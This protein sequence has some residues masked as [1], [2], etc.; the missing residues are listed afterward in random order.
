MVH[1]EGI[2]TDIIYYNEE[3]GYV[4][5]ILETEDE[6]VSIKG[7]I[8]FAQEGDRIRVSGQIEM[9]STYGEQLNVKRSEHLKPTEAE[10]ILKYLSSG[11]ITGIGEATAKLLV[12]TFGEQTLTIIEKEPHRLLEIPGIGKKKLEGIILSYQEQFALRDY[13][14]FFQALGLT[15]NMAMKIHKRYGIEGIDVVERNPYVLADDVIG[16]GFKLADQ[17]ALKMGMALDSPF[18]IES[19]ILYQLSMEASQGNT[20]VYYDHLN[21]MVTR[22]LQLP[23]QGIEHE[24]RSMAM[25]GSIHLEVTA[26][27]EKRVYLPSLYYAE[28]Q[29]ASKLYQLAVG[30]SPVEDFDTDAFIERFQ[31]NRGIILGEK[32]QHALKALLENG[33]F[34]LTGGPGTGK[35]TLINAMIQAYESKGKRITLC[36]PTG[37]AAKR[38]SE[39]TSREAKTIHRLLEFQGE[40]L[41]AKNAD[42]PIE[43][44]ILVIDEVSMVDIVLMYRLL[45]AIAVGTRVIFVGDYDQLPSVGPGSV[46]KDMLKSQCIEQVA[47]DEIYRQS[48][49]SLI[50]INAHLI[51]KGLQ[52][53][54][55]KQ[56]KDFFFI[57]KGKA[58][59]IVAEIKKLV[60]ERL[61]NYYGFNPIED[62]QILTPMKNTDVGVNAL[63][64]MLQEVMNPFDDKKREKKF[65]HRLYREGDKV[66][67]IKNNY[68]LEWTTR[69]GEEGTGVFNGDIGFITAIEDIDRT[70]TVIF[71]GD[72]EVVYDYPMLE[73]LVL[74]YAI[75][76]HKSQGSEFK[77]VVMPMVFGPPMLMSRNILYTGITRARELV[78]LVGDKRALSDMIGRN[79]EQ[80]RLSALHERLTRFNTL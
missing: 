76:V 79:R 57:Q 14:M 28:Q 32:Q 37:R 67:Q 38:M 59:D 65:G 19:G 5:G 58:G 44:D 25:K 40:H 51:N 11:I 2:L 6:Q 15:V 53:T 56:D 36:A 63:N 30:A 70:V 47:L 54:L 71:D 12:R 66:M 55:N 26:Q 1:L 22:T 68:T 33:L 73:E 35:T 42:D 61:P 62:I 49:A 69:H 8:P 52:P 4:I 41:F 17:I 39:A 46:L 45:D 74:A 64:D 78:V 23:Q 43:A 29:V 48:E 3:N 20:Y 18:R 9:H 7:V 31:S 34:I 24:M 27:E 13:I 75:T 60:S 77:V 80:L 16:I 10:D 72:R 50:A 21:N